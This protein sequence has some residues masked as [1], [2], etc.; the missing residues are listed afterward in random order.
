MNSDCMNTS[1][2]SVLI[3]EKVKQMGYSPV[4]LPADNETYILFSYPCGENE[5]V[6]AFKCE[7]NSS[8]IYLGCVYRRKSQYKF[9]QKKY[10][11]IKEFFLSPISK[12]NDRL[13]WSVPHLSVNEDPAVIIKKFYEEHFVPEKPEDTKGAMDVAEDIRN[14]SSENELTHQE[15]AAATGHLIISYNAEEGGIIH[16]AVITK[17]TVYVGVIAERN[18]AYVQWAAGQIPVEAF[19]IEEYRKLLYDAIE[20]LKSNTDQYGLPAFQATYTFDAKRMPFV[21]NKYI[22]QHKLFEEDNNGEDN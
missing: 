8:Y 10:W 17:E 2:Y 6:F 16:S 3:A 13:S 11:D 5:I 1:Q 22:E 19:T 18:T 9:Y 12:I 21:I 15:C 4:I 20:A 14:F 7:K